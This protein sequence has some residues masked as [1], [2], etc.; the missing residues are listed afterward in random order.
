MNSDIFNVILANLIAVKYPK[1]E[2]KDISATVF[3]DTITKEKE[4]CS[5]NFVCRLATF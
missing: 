2:Y 5:L 1:L 4:K 3:F